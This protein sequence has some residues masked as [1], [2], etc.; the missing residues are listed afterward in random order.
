MEV[1]R[2]TGLGFENL[3]N[4]NPDIDPWLPPQGTKLMLPTQTILPAG[5]GRGLTINLA[6]MRLYAFLPQS[7][8]ILVYPL[9]IGREGRNTPEGTFKVINKKVNPIWRVPAGLR[10]EDPSLPRLVHPG[11]DNPLGSY[12][13]GL[14][15]PGYGIHGTNRP[16]GVGRKVSY[17]CLRMYPEH[18]EALF[19]M[20]APGTPVRIVYQPAKAAKAFEMGLRK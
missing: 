6:E 4:A 13:L 17:G 16:F 14:T 8:E 5:A 15:A 10:E 19:P 20:V 1:A 18:I 7:S 2:R 11:P 12:W 9:G 3:A